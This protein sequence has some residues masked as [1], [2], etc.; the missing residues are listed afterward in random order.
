M[1]DGSWGMECDG[2][3]FF[4]FWAIFCPFNPLNNPENQNFEKT[5]KKKTLTEI[6][7]FH[8]CVA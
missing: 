5:I 8:A 7:S 3:N 6:L 4:S 1:I 2:H